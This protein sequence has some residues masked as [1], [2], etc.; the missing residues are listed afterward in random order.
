[1]LVSICL[2]ELYPST[3]SL[4]NSGVYPAILKW[5]GLE[6]G[7]VLVFKPWSEVGVVKTRFLTFLH[8]ILAIIQ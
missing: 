7:V 2:S 5:S 4:T 3:S 1:M 8:I 6:V